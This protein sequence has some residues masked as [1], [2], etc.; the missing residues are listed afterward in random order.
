M[1]QVYLLFLS[2][3]MVSPLLAQQPIPAQKVPI[4]RW[5]KGALLTENEP[6]DAVL[7]R[8]S[9]E[10]AIQV[11]HPELKTLSAAL[12]SAS[13]DSIQRALAPI[14]AHLQQEGPQ[15]RVQLSSFVRGL[16]SVLSL[17]PVVVATPEAAS[18]ELEEAKTETVP[19]PSPAVVFPTEWSTNPLTLIAGLAVVLAL[20]LA[21]L[22]GVSRRQIKR[23]RFR[24][25]DALTRNDQ[26]LNTLRKQVQSQHEE[27]KGLRE[28][29][30]TLRQAAGRSWRT[31]TVGEEPVEQL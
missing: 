12:A 11:Y 15:K 19:E 14:Q 29:A 31:P 27:I 4:T 6:L 8:L 24:E 18:E 26:L 5:E 23:L 13:P 2:W 28:E 10:P 21:L 3:L 1:K 25:R 20:I 9:Q 7:K 30:A 17:K 16:D 22:Y